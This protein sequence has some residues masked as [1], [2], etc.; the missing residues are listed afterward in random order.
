MHEEKCSILSQ[1]AVQFDR[2]LAGN[3]KIAWILNTR[4]IVYKSVFAKVTAM[5]I[6]IFTD[7]P[8]RL[9]L[10]QMIEVDQ[11]LRG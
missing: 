8:A 10:S 6:V 9:N 11:A 2:I 7:S 4:T 5:V 1:R 3:R